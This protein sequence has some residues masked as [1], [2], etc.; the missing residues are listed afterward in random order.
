M[1]LKTCYQETKK[2]NS[3][4]TNVKKNYFQMFKNGIRRFFDKKLVRVVLIFCIL[5]FLLSTVGETLI[6]VT[7]ASWFLADIPWRL[8]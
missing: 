5:F 1:R 6:L 4:E 8:S 7:I 3:I 2:V